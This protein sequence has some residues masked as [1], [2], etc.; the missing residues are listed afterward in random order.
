MGCK[1][2][3]A[4]HRRKGYRAAADMLLENVDILIAIYDSERDTAKGGSKETHHVAQQRKI[5]VIHINTADLN[6]INLHR[7]LTRFTETSEPVTDSNIDE[8]LAATLLPASTFNSESAGNKVD[9]V[10][11]NRCMDDACH[12][13]NEPSIKK[14]GLKYYATKIFHG[15]YSPAWKIFYK[16][17]KL[18]ESQ[19]TLKV[20]CQ[21]AEVKANVT[22]DIESSLYCKLHTDIDALAVQ[23]M[24]S[25]RGSFI[26][27]FLFGAAAV[28]LAVFS[29][30]ADGSH[31][32]SIAELVFLALILVT[33]LANRLGHW[34]KKAVDYRFISE[35]FRHVGV[36]ALLGRSTQLLQPAPEHNSHHDPATTWMG[37]YLNAVIRSQG[38]FRYIVSSTSGS[39]IKGI[40]LDH[41]YVETVKN[42]MCKDWLED[43]YRYHLLLTK[44][45]ERWEKLANGSML[46]LFLL[47]IFGV[48]AHLNHWHWW[49]PAGWDKNVFVAMVVT[50]F[51]ALLAAIHGITVQGEVERL[52]KRS[53]A[54][55]DYLSGMIERFIK[56]EA[57]H[58]QYA[59]VIG[60]HAVE[61][62][63]VMLEEVTDWQILYRAH[64]VELT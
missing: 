2:S 42:M 20:S 27:N 30:F 52:A 34:K 24:D 19:P 39:V 12:F 10:K 62:A 60:D 57:N 49:Y 54:T 5:P 31:F 40:H 38:L 18:G 33:Y 61:A 26:L 1:S 56:I 63:Q 51:P 53:E 11:G 64:R 6:E 8:V 47:I 36:L 17:L 58:P 3:T 22:A 46:I 4:E 28:F 48:V 23:Y 55:A 35:Y 44:R 32:W 41:A 45:Y 21:K 9:T 59:D 25:Y 37:W 7:K 15:F 14:T 43:Q 13:F 16:L 50:A 29:Y